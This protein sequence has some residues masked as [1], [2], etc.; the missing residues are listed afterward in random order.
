MQGYCPTCRIADSA[1]QYFPLQAMQAGHYCPS[2]V[3]IFLDGGRVVA[4]E[5][6]DFD[7]LK[8]FEGAKGE[9]GVGVFMSDDIQDTG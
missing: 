2:S 5:V 4:L 3:D 1:S 7:R 8:S 9:K 6:V